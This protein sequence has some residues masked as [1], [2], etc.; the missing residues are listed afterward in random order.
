MMMVIL[1]LLSQ[2]LQQLEIWLIEKHWRKQQVKMEILMLIQVTR[3]PLKEVLVEEVFLST[4]CLES[5][6]FSWG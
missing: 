1:A 3:F 6:S 2:A 5:S 4:L